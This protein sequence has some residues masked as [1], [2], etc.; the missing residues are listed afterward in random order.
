MFTFFLFKFVPL[1]RVYKG[2]DPV[3]STM[4]FLPLAAGLAMTFFLFD[5]IAYKFLSII[6][7]GSVY[8]IFDHIDFKKR[9]TKEDEIER[10]GSKF[11]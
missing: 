10:C 2:S 9:R 1:T 11:T 7:G 5:D 8:I 3:I 4:G 6:L